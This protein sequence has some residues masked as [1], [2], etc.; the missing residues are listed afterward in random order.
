M[1][2]KQMRGVLHQYDDDM[3]VAF[4]VGGLNTYYYINDC[5][6]EL[7]LR[8]KKEKAIIFSVIKGTEEKL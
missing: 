3:E 1:N 5:Q 4:Y 8:T 6:P 2:V 7:N